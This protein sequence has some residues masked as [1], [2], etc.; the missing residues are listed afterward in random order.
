MLSLVFKYIF[1][2]LELSIIF[3][4]QE[5]RKRGFLKADFR[6]L[7]LAI[8]FCVTK[9]CDISIFLI[10]STVHAYLITYFY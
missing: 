7:F 10:L 2:S 3:D 6:S 8:F 4:T 9:K 5:P 1:L